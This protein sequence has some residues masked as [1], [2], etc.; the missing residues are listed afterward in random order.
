MSGHEESAYSD[1]E[2]QRIGRLDESAEG[3]SE[4]GLG[5]THETG[6]SAAEERE[7]LVEKVP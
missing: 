6:S 3:V 4:E 1:S 5:A 2:E 7:T